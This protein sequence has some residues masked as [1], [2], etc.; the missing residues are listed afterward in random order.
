MVH[1]PRGGNKYRTAGKPSKKKSKQCLFSKWLPLTNEHKREHQQ[2][3][4]NRLA[5]FVP[6][7]ETQTD[8]WVLCSPWRKRQKS[9]QA[10]RDIMLHIS[11]PLEPNTMNC[12]AICKNDRHIFHPAPRLPAFASALVQWW[13]ISEKK[14]WNL[15]LPFYVIDHWTSLLHIFLKKFYF[16]IT[17]IWV[18]NHNLSCTLKSVFEDTIQNTP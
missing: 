18:I 8:N 6:R 13:E 15:Y 11:S 14:Y 3:K 10:K 1:L 17:S 2:Q 16:G 9:T 7:R 4:K 5:A 12:C